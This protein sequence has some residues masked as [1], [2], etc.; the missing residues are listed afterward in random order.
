MGI[1][2]VTVHRLRLNHA[3]HASTSFLQV[4]QYVGNTVPDFLEPDFPR[5]Y[6]NYFTLSRAHFTCVFLR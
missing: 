1:L 2:Q 3:L 5:S 4:R 6:E